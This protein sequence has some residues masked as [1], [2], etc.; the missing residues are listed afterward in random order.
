M[1][2]AATV[3]KKQPRQLSFKLTLQLL[4]AF[5]ERGIFQETDQASYS[6]LLKA[7]VNKIVGN[8]P[9]RQEPRRIKRRPKPYPLLMK[10]RHF[11][12]KKQGLNA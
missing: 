7:A 12:H 5:R 11:Y 3:Y 9:G 10:P 8:R 1:A 4:E 6:Q 2:Q